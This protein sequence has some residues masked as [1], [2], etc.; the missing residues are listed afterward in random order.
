MDFRELNRAFYG[1]DYTALACMIGFGVMI[2]L[3]YGW[4]QGLAA[5]FFSR[6]LRS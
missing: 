3:S 2:G 5:F 6:L 4:K 1:D